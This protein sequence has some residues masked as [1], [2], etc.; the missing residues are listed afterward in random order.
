MAY[1]NITKSIT[2]KLNY[3]HFVKVINTY[4]ATAFDEV[5]YFLKIAISKKL[6][7]FALY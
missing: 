5:F 4:S 1:Y 3:N 7:T 2:L 6:C